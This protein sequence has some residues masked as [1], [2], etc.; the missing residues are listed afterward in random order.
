ML[1]LSGK[2]SVI[3]DMYLPLAPPI[4]KMRY[5]CEESECYDS[6]ATRHFVR[7]ALHA[8]LA[9]PSS[10]IDGGPWRVNEHCIGRQLE[11]E[12]SSL[13]LFLVLVSTS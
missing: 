13:E 10:G 11:Y 7:S 8:H 5:S 4:E 2:D 6:Q 12:R 3:R 1:L 9:C